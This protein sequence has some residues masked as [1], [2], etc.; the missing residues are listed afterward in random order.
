MLDHYGFDEAFADIQKSGT[1]N[2]LVKLTAHLKELCDRK[3][4]SYQ[5]SEE[6]TKQKI[7]NL[8]KE[9]HKLQLDKENVNN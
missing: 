1:D 7:E 6:S 9:I 8:Q 3:S 5:N 2:K 4:L